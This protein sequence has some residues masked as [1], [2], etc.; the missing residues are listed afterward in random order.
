MSDLDGSAVASLRRLN[1]AKVLGVLRTE[2]YRKFTVREMS[3]ATGLSRPTVARLLD[4]LQEIG[5]ALSAEGKPGATG[6]PARRYW[7]NRLRGLLVSADLGLHGMALMV[8]DL[9][10]TELHWSI[11]LGQDLED[12]A[13]A[14]AFMVKAFDDVVRPLVAEHKE[15]AEA[16]DLPVMAVSVSAPIFT[17]PDGK[18]VDTLVG[19][20]R[21]AEGD[22]IT[23]VK[24]LYGDIPVILNNDL[25]LTAEAELHL[26]GLRG[27][28]QGLVV[29]L[30]YHSAV[31]LVTNGHVHEGSTHLAGDIG[32]LKEYRWRA[33][34]DEANSTTGFSNPP[35]TQSMIDDALGGNE[36]G[37][38]A[39]EQLGKGFTRG[40]VDVAALWD[41]DIIVFTGQYAEA[42]DVVL[43]PIRAGLNELGQGDFDLRVS[44]VDPDKGACLGGVIRALDAVNW[45]A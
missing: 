17:D 14:T 39:L 22:F 43:D 29:Y 34:I 25:M 23:P 1:G 18:I 30:A 15:S 10:G 40:I 20:E 3:I 5:W 35:R 2:A 44:N 4:D 45:N 41:P 27:S 12:P 19:V 11:V 21:W 28:Q 8:T 26:G 32:S 36:K 24:E 6:R 7:F 37:L 9:I 13:A 33:M 42:G 16:E 31:I 38:A